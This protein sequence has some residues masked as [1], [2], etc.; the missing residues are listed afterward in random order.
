M[1][2]ANPDST[3]HDPHRSIFLTDGV[4]AIAVTLLALDLKPD[5]SR[6]ASSGDL[7]HYLRTHASQ[8]FAFVLAFFLIARFW[9]L[10]HRTMSGVRALDAASMWTNMLFL[11]AITC[12]PLTTY[13]QGTYSASL[14]TVLFAGNLLVVSVSLALLGDL[15]NRRGLTKE[16]ESPEARVVR[17]WRMIGATAVPVVVI[18][19]AW[20]VRHADYFF[21]L[22]LVS[23]IPA[24]LAV[25]RMQRRSSAA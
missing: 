4:V 16:P 6:D 9:I 19:L 22:A 21:L 10:H 24:K 7:A 5:L 25:R 14:A 17:R 18:I 23:D 20:A 3:L 15:T 1:A 12:V 13:I 8:Y 11:F 2:D